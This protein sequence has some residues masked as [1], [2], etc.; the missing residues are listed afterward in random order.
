MVAPLVDVVFQLLLFF[1]L[2]TKYI[3]PSMAIALPDADIGN[4][5]ERQSVTVSIDETGA[6][7]LN[8]NPA[9]LQEIKE[10]LSEARQNG[11]IEF[12]RLRADE[13]IEFQKVIDVFEAIQL[14]GMIDIAI[15]T[16]PREEGG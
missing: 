15:E 10:Q 2:I 13:G 3:S 1:M 4:V 11:E 16:K 14:S 9:S 6:T 12:V 8:E 7:F 5:D